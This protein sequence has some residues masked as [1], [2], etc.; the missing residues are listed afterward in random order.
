MKK[1]LTILVVL[2]TCVFLSTAYA[3]PPQPQY[4][5]TAVAVT[6]GTID[7]ATIGGTTAGTAR[8]LLDEDAEP[9]TDNVTANQCAG[10]LINNYGQT[11]NATLTLPAIAAGYNFTVIIG[12]TVAKYYR[13][14]PNANDS[15]YIDSATAGDGKY[16]GVASAVAGNCISCAA[17]QTG[18]SAYDWLCTIISGAWVSE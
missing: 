15:I 18:D 13:I 4:N 2:L 3:F 16:V 17:F 1:G 5:P 12:T 10:G 6:G 9:A 14:D 7:G 11:D 8:I